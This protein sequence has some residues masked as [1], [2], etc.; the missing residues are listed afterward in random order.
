[1]KIK[2]RKSAYASGMPLCPVTIDGAVK[3]RTLEEMRS[4]YNGLLITLAAILE[5]NDG[6]IFVNYEDV[7]KVKRQKRV[8]QIIP[9][10]VSLALQ[11]N[12]SAKAAPTEST[13]EAASSFLNSNA[14]Q[15]ARDYLAK[16]KE[17]NDTK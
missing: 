3:P 6:R 17:N 13:T 9:G 11:F 10:E 7:D 12:T 2:K 5:R 16:Q 14:A 1:M 4:E 8:L 15:E